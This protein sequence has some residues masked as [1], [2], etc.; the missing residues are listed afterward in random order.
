MLKSQHVHL[1]QTVGE[2]V[3]DEDVSMVVVPRGASSPIE[4]PGCDSHPRPRKSSPLHTPTL[5]LS[6][7]RQLKRQQN[8][9]AGQVVARHRGLT[10][11]I[12]RAATFVMT[13]SACGGPGIGGRATLID[14]EK[15]G[16]ISKSTIDAVDCHELAA[17][18]GKRDDLLII[19]SRSFMDYNTHHIRRAVNVANSKIGKRRLQQERVSVRD[20]LVNNCDADSYHWA[21]LYDVNSR[22]AAQLPADS[23]QAILLEK[24]AA[25]FPRVS[26]LNGGFAE[27]QSCYPSLVEDK[28]RP[29]AP[30]ASALSQPCM[31]TTNAGL[32]RILPFL[33]LGSQQDAH[34]RQLLWDHNITY[35]LNVSATC[36]KADFIP[37]PQFLRIAVNDNYSEKLLPHFS[38]AS[39]FVERARESGGCVLVHCLAGVSRSPTMAIAYVMKHLRLSSDDAYRY[40]KSKRPTISP[41]FNFLGQL[42][43]YEKELRREKILEASADICS[44][45][46]VLSPSRPLSPASALLSPTREWDLPVTISQKKQRLSP[47]MA[48]LPRQL[49]LTLKQRPME[50]VQASPP[51]GN[52]PASGAVSP[53]TGIARLN[54]GGSQENLSVPEPTRPF[55]VA[56]SLSCN[57]EWLS[58]HEDEN[59]PPQKI[60]RNVSLSPGLERPVE[61]L[62]GFHLQQLQQSHPAAQPADSSMGKRKD[63]SFSKALSK[64][65]SGASLR[66]HFRRSDSV[67]TSGTSGYGSQISDH[68]DTLED[69][70]L[71]DSDESSVVLRASHIQSE[72]HG[73]IKV[74]RHD[75]A[76]RSMT[77]EESLALGSRESRDKEQQKYKPLGSPLSPSEQH[78]VSDF[79]IETLF[80]A[81]HPFRVDPLIAHGCRREA[82]TR[83]PL[84]WSSQCSSAHTELESSHDSGYIT[85]ISSTSSSLAS[86]IRSSVVSSSTLS[87]CGR[88]ATAGITD[89]WRSQS[90]SSHAELES[91]HDSGIV[92][93]MTSS[94]PS[95]RSSSIM[96][97]PGSSTYRRL[98]AVFCSREGTANVG[99]ETEQRATKM[100]EE[101]ERNADIYEQ[102]IAEFEATRQFHTKTDAKFAHI[103]NRVRMSAEHGKQI[104]LPRAR[105]LPGLEVLYASESVSGSN[106]FHGQQPRNRHSYSGAVDLN[107]ESPGSPATAR[108]AKT[109]N[110]QMAEDCSPPAVPLV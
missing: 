100:S 52:S 74:S 55:E 73:H 3:S 31:P 15:A 66:R 63:H 22:T 60:E 90:S 103:A 96:S 58:A 64:T 85:S 19:D 76:Y 21:V 6:L 44:S 9:P 101:C 27:F 5:S 56:R 45:A 40:V 82:E 4:C 47:R 32:T 86:S 83:V 11:S 81:D 14:D 50:T 65:L 36:P 41:N 108:I 105:S 71:S 107:R 13:S 49:T 59:L 57:L 109:E 29:C 72:H 61:L 93:S 77:F 42:L 16:A 33:Y 28:Q 78:L 1:S 38:K 104:A 54:F 84:L 68:L 34:N 2:I 30:L 20:L 48:M 88:R 23:F 43:E 110:I 10:V 24:L 51:E 62:P 7:E 8:L 12:Q 106:R 91:S 75:S 79:E 95:M 46:P 26:L 87:A 67:S 37:E 102:I 92:A 18:L 17:L 53:T 69:D 70:I 97:L 99:S 80:E 94:T 25:V 39:H 35:V 98:R 89:S